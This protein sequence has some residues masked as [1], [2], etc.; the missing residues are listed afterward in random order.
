[1]AD[2]CLDVQNVIFDAEKFGKPF[3]IARSAM[4]RQSVDDPKFLPRRIRCNAN[5]ETHKLNRIRT[6][7]PQSMYTLTAPKTTHKELLKRL[8][9]DYLIDEVLVDVNFSV[10]LLVTSNLKKDV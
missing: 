9:M 7:Q 3:A 4:A 10:K 6:P 2:I 1:M 8:K 5:F